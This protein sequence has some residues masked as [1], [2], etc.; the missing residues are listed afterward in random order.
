MHI[1]FTLDALVDSGKQ[2]W[3]LKA[4]RQQWRTALFA[5]DVHADDAMFGDEGE[6]R[7]QLGLRMVNDPSLGLIPQGKVGMF[8]FLQ[9][10]IFTHAVVHRMGCAPLPDRD[11][12]IATIT[13]MEPGEAQLLHLDLGAV[14]RSRLAIDLVHNL[15]IAVRGE[16]ASSER[17]IGSKAAA[18]MD[19]IDA[20]WQQ[21]VAGWWLHLV[22]RRI[23]CFIPN[24]EQSPPVNESLAKISQFEPELMP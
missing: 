19:Y 22:S 7:S 21:F 14:F 5:E 6:V 23:N 12:M 15:A 9:R 11:Q 18:N 1:L 20:L 4:D 8:D 13:A 24:L 16:V 10:G 17:Y 3:R 2:A